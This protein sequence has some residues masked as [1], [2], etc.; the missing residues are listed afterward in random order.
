MDDYLKIP[1]QWPEDIVKI[2][3]IFYNVQLVKYIP[4]K[5]ISILILKSNQVIVFVGM[6]SLKVLDQTL[7]LLII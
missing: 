5:Q 7:Y 4:Y 6:V 1:T 3:Y 2:L